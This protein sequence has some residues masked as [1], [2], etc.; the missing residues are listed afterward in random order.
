[1]GEPQKECREGAAVLPGCVTDPAGERGQTHNLVPKK[2]VVRAAPGGRGQQPASSALGGLGEAGPST[3]QPTPGR[4]FL[5]SRGPG[6]LS[7][8]ALQ[9][10]GGEARGTSPHHEMAVWTQTS[11][12]SVPQGGPGGLSWGPS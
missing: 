11:D 4:T 7:R 6:P 12:T 8:P 2:G 9:S 1:M 5:E 3:R 10:H